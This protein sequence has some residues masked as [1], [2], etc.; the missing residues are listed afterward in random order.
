MKRLFLIALTLIAMMVFSACESCKKDGPY[1]SKP[2]ITQTEPKKT[3]VVPPKVT[4]PEAAPPKVVSPK[5]KRP[6]VVTPKTEPKIEPPKTEPEVVTPKV[7][8]PKTEPKT[9]VVPKAE[10]PKKCAVQ[11]KVSIVDYWIVPRPSGMVPDLFAITFVVKNPTPKDV[12]VKVV[13]HYTDGSLF[14]ESIPQTVDA[15]SDAKLMVRGFKR[16][17][18]GTGCLESF[19]CRVEAVN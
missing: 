14:G 7:E 5:T 13:C 15:N 18:R 12:K 11:P 8:P 1:N 10:P 2:V 16:C 4:P 17:P 19:D 3:E 9:P 6:K